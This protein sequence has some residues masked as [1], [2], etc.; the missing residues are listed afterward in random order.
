MLGESKS[1]TEDVWGI[2]GLI[3]TYRSRPPGSGPGGVFGQGCAWVGA[4][5]RGARHL[6]ERESKHP[7][8]SFILENHPIISPA[9]TP[10][11]FNG[12]G[13]KRPPNRTKFDRRSSYNII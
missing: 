11:R 1:K 4:L 6:D 10:H 12:S 2:S 8:A 9:L 13:I 3:R 5:C 7:V